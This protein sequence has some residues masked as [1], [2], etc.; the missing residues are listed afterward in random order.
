MSIIKPSGS[1]S[2]KISFRLITLRKVKK[3][4]ILRLAFTRGFARKFQNVL[5][6]FFYFHVL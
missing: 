5:K 6:L 1:F 2:K 4:N 3:K